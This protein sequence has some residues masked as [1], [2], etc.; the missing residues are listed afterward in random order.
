MS[1]SQRP[2]SNKLILMRHAKSDWNDARLTDKA[3]PL[4][5]RGRTACSR[6]GT[7]VGIAGVLSSFGP[8]QYR[9][10]NVSNT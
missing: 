8:V 6:D 5:E 9:G 1:E 10:A 3:R 7:M 2:A 4:N